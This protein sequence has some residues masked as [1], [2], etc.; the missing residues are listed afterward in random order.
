M[1]HIQTTSGNKNNE[2]TQNAKL[3]GQTLN[4]S[5]QLRILIDV[6]ARR[7][8]PN[9]WPYGWSMLPVGPKA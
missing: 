3:L 5:P 9:Q 8:L 4:T 1:N 2:S 7:R 6:D